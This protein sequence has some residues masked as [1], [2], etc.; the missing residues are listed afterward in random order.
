MGNAPLSV[1]LNCRLIGYFL[2][3]TTCN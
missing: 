1:T 2:S 3:G